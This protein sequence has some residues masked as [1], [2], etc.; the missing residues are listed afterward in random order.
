MKSHH[1]MQWSFVCQSLKGTPMHTCRVLSLHSF[2]FTSILRHRFQPLSPRELRFSSQCSKTTM[3]CLGSLSLDYG[4]YC[5]HRM[6]LQVESQ[7]HHKAS[8]FVS[9]LSAVR[10]ILPVVQCL[11]KIVPRIL[12]SFPVVQCRSVRL[13]QSLHD[14]RQKTLSHRPESLAHICQYLHTPMRAGMSCSVRCVIFMFYSGSFQV[15]FAA[16]TVAVCLYP[17]S[18]HL[19]WFKCD[20]FVFDTLQQELQVLENRLKRQFEYV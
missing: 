13:Y 15:D 4:L 10:S 3:L 6:C 7:S 17:S 20:S 5:R 19:V 12:F 9:L 1:S 2:L 11:K 8:S 18:L 16:Y 14:M